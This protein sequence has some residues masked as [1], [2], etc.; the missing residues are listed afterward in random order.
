MPQGLESAVTAIPATAEAGPAGARPTDAQWAAIAARDAAAAFDA[1]FVI[2]VKTTRIYCRVG[3]PARTPHRDN[4]VLFAAPDAAEMAGFRACKR[5]HPRARWSDPR[6]PLVSA[7][8]AHIAAHLAEPGQLTL[9]A[10]S[11]QFHYEAG[12]LAAAF[13]AV[14]GLSPREYAE[15]LRMRALRSELAAGHSV[16]DAIHAVGY[17]SSSRVYERTD[18]HLGMTPALYRRGGSGM[19]V[20]YSLAESP[21]GVLAAARTLRGIARISLH[22]DAEA[23]DA[24]V[25]AEFRNAEVVRDDAGAAAELAAIVAH[26]VQGAPPPDLA[27]DISATA[28]QWKV[29]NA[30]CAIPRGETRTYSQVAQAIGQPSAV[31]AVA[32][33]CANN[34]AALVI[35]CHRVVGKDGS[36]TGYRWGT[37]RKGLL[38]DAEQHSV[39]AEK[40]S[41]NAEEAHG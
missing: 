38:L 8:C 21:F 28:F 34:R 31:R 14:L 7:V 25:R 17:G 3:C 18:T 41:V 15:W 33:A 6:V 29:W 1:P 24:A 32:S 12:T 11:A 5:C 36:L 40:H 4:V 35:P 22:D 10:L 9:D 30:L 27:F 16:T 19:T 2:A 13:R 39:N 20:T 23:A 26:I 37:G